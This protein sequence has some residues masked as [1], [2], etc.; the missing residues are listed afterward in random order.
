MAKTR[1]K[2]TIQSTHEGRTMRTFTTAFL[3]TLLMTGLAL[4]VPVIAGPGWSGGPGGCQGAGMGPGG[5]PYADPAA[6][7]ERLAG[8]L[9][10]SDE[11][12]AQVQTIFEKAQPEMQ[13]L[14]TEM[15]E[16]RETIRSLATG[17][18]ASEAEI[19]KLA[20]TQGTKVAE[21]IV[22]RSGVHNEISAVLTDAQR[23]QFAQMGPRQ[24]RGRMQ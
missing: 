1:A 3:A 20:N 7:V 15:M 2:Y 8:R 16:N 18:K 9:D 10:L 12:R 4:S 23:E 22:L 17:N 21:M 11:Q 13:K 6:R 24:G 19:R 14:R 5:G